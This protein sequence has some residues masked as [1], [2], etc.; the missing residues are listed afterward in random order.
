MAASIAWPSCAGSYDLFQLSSLSLSR[1]RGSPCEI[2]RITCA[3]GLGDRYTQHRPWGQV[4]GIGWHS[5]IELL[6]TRYSWGCHALSPLSCR[7]RICSASSTGSSSRRHCF[8]FPGTRDFNFHCVRPKGIP[9]YPHRPSRSL[10]SAL[11]LASLHYLYVRNETCVMSANVFA[12]KWL[13][14]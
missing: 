4:N 9:S 1:H 10:F 2:P 12:C 7:L 14:S 13:H 6:L 3:S 5:S 8:S 11:V